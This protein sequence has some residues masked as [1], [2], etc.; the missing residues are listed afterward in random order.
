MSYAT[1]F[2]IRLK[3]ES[4]NINLNPYKHVSTVIQKQRRREL[5][6]ITDEDDGEKE[7]GHREMKGDGQCRRKYVVDRLMVRQRRCCGLNRIESG[8]VLED[9]TRARWLLWPAG[10]DPVAGVEVV[11]MIDVGAGECVTALR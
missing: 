2:T 1:N 4:G 7:G 3:N 11:A 9:L 6:Y 10:G 8:R 5:V